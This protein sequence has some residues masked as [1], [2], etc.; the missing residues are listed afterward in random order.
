[1]IEYEQYKSDV[2]TIAG[3]SLPWEKL[4]Q[5]ELLITGATGLIGSFLI[6]VLME[7]NTAY[8]NEINIR[9]A[10]RSPEK[11][12][13]RFRDHGIV[14]ENEKAGDFG[15]L[16]FKQW[17]VTAP[18]PE[19]EMTYDYI[20]HGA[21]NTHPRAYAA[22]PVGTITGNVTGLLNLMEH[23][24]RRRPQRVLLM[25]S[26]EIY[27]ENV[28]AIP[29]FAESDLGYID[30]NTVRAGYPESKRL[31]ES[32]CQAYA[33]QYG[34]EFVTG[35]FSRVY[36]PTMQ[37]EDSKALAQF[38]R[39][40]VSG[41]N[42]VLKSEGK[43]LYSYTYVADAVS[44]L[45]FLLLK[46]KACEAYNIADPLS[47]LTLKELAGLLADFS[48][49]RVVCELPD[50]Q[51]RAG[52]SAATHA[53]LDAAKLKSLGWHAMFPIET[54]LAHTVEILTEAAREAQR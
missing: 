40:A 49:T 3:L 6:D 47:D 17:D 28:Q 18:L 44:A 25:S 11:A 16:F 54:G 35:R 39:N 38:I 15:R 41:G 27:G 22:D 29:A 5:K 12:K 43:Q 8:A 36:G 34:V 24:R 32:I 42:I 7:R 13:S 37:E 46:G 20:I 45:L 2:K 10:G 4:R 23:A 21:S 1:M 26:V 31:S 48:G 9:A 33:A 14:M 53:V 50:E 52:Y 51:E 30:C 19:N